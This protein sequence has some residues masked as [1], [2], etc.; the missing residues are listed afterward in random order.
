MNAYY[1]IRCAEDSDSFEA[2]AA[3][4]DGERLLLYSFGSGTAASL[5]SVR[6]RAPHACAAL[7]AQVHANLSTILASSSDCGGD[8][9]ELSP[10]Q[11]E[12]RMSE[13]ERDYGRGAYLYSY[14]LHLKHWFCYYSISLAQFAYLW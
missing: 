1:A 5:F 6:V 13:R 8:R 14:L 11:F 4:L 12:Q 7:L 10:E 9:Y 2:A 3:R